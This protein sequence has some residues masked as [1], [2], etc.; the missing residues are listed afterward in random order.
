[1]QYIRHPAAAFLHLFLD[2]IH[3]VRVVHSGHSFD[4]DHRGADGA[5]VSIE[6]D[7]GGLKLLALISQSSVVGIDCPIVELDSQLIQLR[8]KAADRVVKRSKQQLQKDA[9]GL[10]RAL[11]DLAD[12]FDEVF[13]DVAQD[14]RVPSPDG[15]YVPVSAKQVHL[16]E[17]PGWFG[18]PGHRPELFSFDCQAPGL[19][20]PLRPGD[21]GLF[22]PDL[23]QQVSSL[24]IVAAANVEPVE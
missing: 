4:P 12:P 6:P 23:A 22:E 21:I 8:V 10:E 11:A 7:P 5:A 24:H 1:M 18:Q 13:A 14:R 19:P 20:K 16:G 3:L 17:R 2:V 15:Q 9:S